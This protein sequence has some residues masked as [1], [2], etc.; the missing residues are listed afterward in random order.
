MKVY[1]GLEQFNKLSYAVVT[2]GTFDG[3]HMGHQKILARL[4]EVRQASAG[5]SVVLTFWPHPRLIVEKDGKELRLLTTIDE[6]INLLAQSGVNHL[7]II[8][9]TK[10]FSRLTSDE[11]VSQI[12]VRKIGT[13]KLVIG[14]DH[15]F[16]RNREGSFEYLVQHAANYG[17]QVEEIPPQDVEH[18]TVSSTR[19]RKALLEGNLSVAN[20]YLGRFYS[21]SGVVVR[22]NQLGRTIGYPTA[23]IRV[24]DDYKLIP[25]DSVYAIR[26]GWRDQ[27]HR[28]MLNIGMRPTVNGT[29]R[30]VETH[31]FDF[32]E[33]IYDEVLTL[34]LVEKIRTEQKFSGLDALKA[35]LRHD[36]QTARRLL[37]QI[38]PGSI[39]G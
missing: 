24:Q 10:E 39:G 19:I 33:D 20:E 35:Q 14:Y 31:I 6:K 29:L 26:V 27:L 12:L 3:V 5:E 17:F 32:N 38:N 11:F 7:V 2:S 21:L 22:G 18:V 16:G 25:E 30:T 4:E 36:E 34:Y 37:G 28:G 1:Q 23:N 9:F 8:P 13:K 15:R